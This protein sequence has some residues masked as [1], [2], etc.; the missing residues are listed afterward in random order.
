MKKIGI[1]VLTCAAMVGLAG[2]TTQQSNSK[3]SVV[4][5][6]Y[7]ADKAPVV[8]AAI[9]VLRLPIKLG[10]AFVPEQGAK[11]SG[12]NSWTGQHLDAGGLSEAQKMQ[13]LEKIAGHFK[14]HEFI[15]DI[16]TIPSVYLTPKGSFTNLDQIK[17]MY[18]IDVIALVSYDQVQFTNEDAL[19]LSYWTLV[20]A[21]LVSGQKNDTQTLVD[22]VVYDIASRKM[23]FRA[24][25]TSLVKGRS[26]PVNL[27]EELRADAATGFDLSV[28]DM[29]KNLDTQLVSFREKVKANPEQI[30]VVKTSAYSGGG[31]LGG[32]SL[33]VLGAALLMR[34]SRHSSNSV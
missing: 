3:S 34:K 20:G 16:Q 32:V 10:I 33:L 31:A 15:G 17:T 12:I 5:Y 18:D 7:P 21:Y 13:I 6:L 19:S 1:L 9:P 8:Q 25:G 23:L 26:T 22:T 30:K 11:V 27:N 29:I 28:V 2:C 4:E 14:A 24:P